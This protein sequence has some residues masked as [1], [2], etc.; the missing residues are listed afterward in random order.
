ME[1]FHLPHSQVLLREDKTVHHK[2]P[3]KIYGNS[4]FKCLVNFSFVLSTPTICCGGS[5]LRK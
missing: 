2:V 3:S 1:G 5:Y 4:N